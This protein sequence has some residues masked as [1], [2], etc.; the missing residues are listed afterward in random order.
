MI[1]EEAGLFVAAGVARGKRTALENNSGRTGIFILRGRLQWWQGG[2]IFFVW[3]EVLSSRMRAMGVVP[4]QILCNA[5]FRCTHIIISFQI[6]P[7]H[8]DVITPGI[9]RSLATADNSVIAKPA[10]RRSEEGISS[11]R[12]SSSI[13]AS[14]A[15]SQTP[16]RSRGLE[17]G[18]SNELPYFF[19]LV[20]ERR[21]SRHVQDYCMA[22][23]PA[24]LIKGAPKKVPS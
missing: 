18:M 8:E 7:F 1:I 22:K 16:T 6:Q 19:C 13:S 9:R 11:T 15:C 5:R 12:A 2:Q 23:R 3:R 21:R 17:S 14:A 10:A 20:I 24:R 4:V